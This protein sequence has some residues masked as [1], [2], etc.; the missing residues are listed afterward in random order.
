[1]LFLLA[2]LSHTAAFAQLPG[3]ECDSY[4]AADSLQVSIRFD[5]ETSGRIIVSN[6]NGYPPI[7]IVAKPFRATPA[8][9]SQL[10]LVSAPD[11]D[12]KYQAT[13]S[14]PAQLASRQTFRTSIRVTRTSAGPI[15]AGLNCKAK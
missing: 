14:V 3:I 4:Q 10:V 13:M 9:D 11:G 15:T 8:G 6:A 12:F 1:M 5:G 2:V 7:S